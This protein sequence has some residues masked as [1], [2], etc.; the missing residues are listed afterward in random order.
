MLNELFGT[1]TGWLTLGVIIFMLGMF[2]FIYR[3]FLKNE[4]KELENK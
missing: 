2:V 3:F 4:A 1:F